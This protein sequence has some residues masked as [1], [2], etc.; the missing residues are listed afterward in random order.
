MAF[1]DWPI[2]EGLVVK[3]TIKPDAETAK[4]WQGLALPR[5]VGKNVFL[6][7]L[8]EPASLGL[9]GMA[10]SRGVAAIADEAARHIR[11]LRAPPPDVVATFTNVVD[12][13]PGPAIIVPLEPDAARLEAFRQ[14]WREILDKAAREIIA[15]LDTGDTCQCADCTERSAGIAS[16]PQTG[17]IRTT[18]ELPVGFRDES[19]EPA[20]SPPASKSQPMPLRALRPGHQRIGLF[21]PK[22]G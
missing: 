15:E 13:D 9:C 6:P 4:L 20:F 11:A 1:T 16:D 17:E 10:P 7:R 8:P 18:R 14:A 5:E 21:T 19:R 2:A 22:P 12:A 3:G